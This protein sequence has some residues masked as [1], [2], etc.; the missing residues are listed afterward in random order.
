MMREPGPTTFFTIYAPLKPVACLI[1]TPSKSISLNITIGF[2]YISFDTFHSTLLTITST[3]SSVCIDL[4]AKE[5]SGF[6][7]LTIS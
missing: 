1:L 2:I 4:K 6:L 5:C 7:S 3:C